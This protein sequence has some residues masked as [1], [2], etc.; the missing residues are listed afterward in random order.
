LVEVSVAAVPSAKA[1][2][3]PSTSGSGPVTTAGRLPDICAVV[4]AL[5]ASIESVSS[6]TG[7]PLGS[8]TR[9]PERWSTRKCCASRPK[10][11]ARV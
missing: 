9:L 6:C 7:L 5:G 2:A 11:P 3:E 1:S 8:S 4:V 10:E